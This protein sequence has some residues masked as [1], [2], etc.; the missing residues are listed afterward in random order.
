MKFVKLIIQSK[1]YQVSKNY[2][3]LFVCHTIKNMTRLMEDINK[4]IQSEPGRTRIVCFVFSCNI[5][6]KSPETNLLSVYTNLKHL[7][8]YFKIFRSKG[9]HKPNYIQQSSLFEMAAN[10]TIHLSITSDRGMLIYICSLTSQ[11]W[12]LK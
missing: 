4:S 8:L 7:F 2:I 9:L 3:C 6:L 11:I 1:Q 5:K 10:F 12:G